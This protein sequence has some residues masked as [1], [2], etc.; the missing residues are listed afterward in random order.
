MK[1]RLGCDFISGEA[2]MQTKND[3]VIKDGLV[4]GSRRIKRVDV[5]V[6]AGK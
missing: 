2:S 6:K 4:I 5:G 3:L 1:S